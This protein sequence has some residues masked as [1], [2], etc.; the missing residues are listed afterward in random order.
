MARTLWSELCDIQTLKRGWHIARAELS[1]DFAEI[2]YAA[3]LVARDLTKYLHDLL[4]SLKAGSYRPG[5]LIEVDVP[6]GPFGIRPG[7]VIPLRD[8][9]VANAIVFLI[10]PKLDRQLKS[11]VY[12]WRVKRPFPKS[13]PIF[14]EGALEDMPFLKAKTIRKWIDPVQPWYALWPRFDERSR[15]VIIGS[16]ARYR[17]LATS[18]IAAYFENIQLPLLREHLLTDLPDEGRIVNL[19]MSMLESWVVRSADGASPDRGIPQGSSIGSFLGNYFLLGLDN[20]I[21]R[22]A[23]SRDITYF[24]YMDDVRIFANTVE[25]ARTALFTMIRTLRMLHLNVQTAKTRVYDESLGEVSKHLTDERVTELAAIREEIALKFANDPVPEPQRTS[26]LHRLGAIARKRTGSE[27]SQPIMGARKPLEGL[28]SRAFRMWISLHQ[29]LKSSAYAGRLL[30]EIEQNPDDKLGQKLIS[31]AKTFPAL[32]GLEGRLLNFVESKKVVFPY[33]KAQCLRAMRYL[34]N[35]SVRAKRHCL[36]VLSLVRTDSHVRIQAAMLLA[37][38]ELTRAELRRV[39]DALD[40]DVDPLSKCTIAAILVQEA[41]NK[42]LVQRLVFE[43]NDHLRLF[44]AFVRTLKNVESAAKA[45]LEH[46]LSAKHSHVRLCDRAALIHVVASSDS[47]E[48]Q[49]IF[50]RRLTSDAIRKAPVGMRTRLRQIKRDLRGQL[51]AKG[52]I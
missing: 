12:S 27:K 10:A 50:F 5:A 7:S 25:D 48:I 11:C 32:R 41:P 26:Y 35:P 34:A 4:A 2:P 36:Q 18:D 16:K 1:R 51:K 37:R 43:A 21:L 20:E 29:R 13:G 14:E 23:R 38:L 24:R 8:R 40:N 31:T 47:T 44:G 9:I 39:R 17:Y 49:R 6:K 45:E 28:S 42:A 46:G 3:D 22:L 15:D 30:R 33:Q 19:L 52:A